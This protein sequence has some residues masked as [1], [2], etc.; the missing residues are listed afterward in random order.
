MY[1]KRTH[2]IDICDLDGFNIFI[3]RL[4]TK[5]IIKKYPTDT[6]STLAHLHVYIIKTYMMMMM[7]MIRGTLPLILESSPYICRALKEKFIP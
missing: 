7:M 1:L 2:Q 4:Y 6:F 5:N 3:S